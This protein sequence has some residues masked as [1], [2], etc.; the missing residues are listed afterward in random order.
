MCPRRFTNKSLVPR[1]ERTHT[2]ENPIGRE[3]VRMLDLPPASSD[4]KPS[5]RLDPGDLG[6]PI[7]FLRRFAQKSDVAGRRPAR[8]ETHEREA[9]RMLDV[10]KALILRC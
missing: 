2:G 1:H 8:A 6:V 10:P 9:I 5:P 3:A 4:G 7:Y